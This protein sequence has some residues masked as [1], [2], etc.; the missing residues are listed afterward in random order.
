M[1]LK[2]IEIHPA[3]ASGKLNSEWF[4]LVNAGD[5]AFSTKHCTLS[6]SRKNSKKR[7]ELGTLDPGFTIAPGERVRVITGNPGKKAHGDLPD[8]PPRNY[9][10]F[11]GNNVVQGPG[12]VL[13]FALRSHVLARAEFDP[14]TDSGVAPA[15]S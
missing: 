9:S 5:A 7:K 11:L 14:N 3:E 13:A 6:I 15:E 12:T 1:K 2:I 10:L 8:S 4:V